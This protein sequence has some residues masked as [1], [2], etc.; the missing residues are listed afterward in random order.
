M[1]A[2]V[3]QTLNTQYQEASERLEVLQKFVYIQNMLDLVITANKTKDFTK[4]FK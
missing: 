1:S 4:A 2:G 3:F